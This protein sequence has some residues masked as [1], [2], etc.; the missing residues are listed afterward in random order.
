MTH[1]FLAIGLLF[2]TLSAAAQIAP[3]L[4]VKPN[5]RIYTGKPEAHYRLCANGTSNKAF[6]RVDGQLVEIIG[7]LDVAG[8]EIESSDSYLVAIRIR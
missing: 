2:A 5:Q 4:E 1:R 8:K 3:P 7:C 6:A